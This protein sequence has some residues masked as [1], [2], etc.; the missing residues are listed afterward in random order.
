MIGLSY[1]LFVTDTPH[2]VIGDHLGVSAQMITN[3][4]SGTKTIADKHLMNLSRYFGVS[5]EVF[6]KELT[7]QDKIEIEM[8]L[9]SKAGKYESVDYQAAA[10]HRQNQAIREKYEEI[11]HALE[12]YAGTVERLQEEIERFHKGFSSIV[13]IDSLMEDPEGCEI[14]FGLLKDL[15]GIRKKVRM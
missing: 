10:L 2:K 12:E 14:V 5:P 3:W 15:Q 11:L 8:Q 13:Q 4:I 1:I 9:A 6:K 7:L